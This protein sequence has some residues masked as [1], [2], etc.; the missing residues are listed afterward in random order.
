[1]SLRSVCSRPIATSMGLAWLL[2]VAAS[3]ADATVLYTY[4]GNAFTVVF[5]GPFTTADFVKVT[6]AMTEPLAADAVTD[7]GTTPNLVPSSLVLSAG[8]YSLRYSDVMPP[9]ISSTQIA[10]NAAG[11]IVEWGIGLITD[12]NFALGSLVGTC[13]FVSERLP[14]L[15][16]CT[17][18]SPDS[19]DV[20]D[21][22][23][24]NDGLQAGFSLLAP[25]VWSAEVIGGT[26][27][28]RTATSSRAR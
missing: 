14:R 26:T 8:N 19:R 20:V 3:A 25:G 9:G 11:E 22:E 12:E 1:M 2:L 21:L 28:P 7:L 18:S 6:F 27:A 17:I 5:S 4:T 10:T 23:P 13:S 16:P 24:I 15:A